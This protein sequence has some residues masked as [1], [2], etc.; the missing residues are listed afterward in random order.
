[1]KS[2][3]FI[4]KLVLATLLV[5][6]LASFVLGVRVAVKECVKAGDKVEEHIKANG[7]KSVFEE[8]WH[9]ESGEK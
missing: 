6:I 9:G 4:C 8:I 7:L 3:N 1:M 2:K 5:L